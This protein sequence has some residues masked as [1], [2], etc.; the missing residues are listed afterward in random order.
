MLEIREEADSYGKKLKGVLATA[1]AIGNDPKTLGAFALN[2]GIEAVEK[3]NHGMH[4]FH[5]MGMTGGQ[6]LEAQ[7]QS[8]SVASLMGLSDTKGAIQGIVEQYGTLAGASAEVTD[9]IGHLAHEMGISGAEAGKLTAEMS[10]MAG[11][12]M[13]T[14]A[15]TLEFTKN[16]AKASGVA[17]GKLTKE[18]AANTKDMALFSKE[19]SKG[20]AKAAMELHKMNVS[21]DAAASAANS[22]LDYETSIEAQ[23]EASALLGREINLDKARELALNHDSAGAMKELVNQAGGLANF[24][25]MNVLEQQ[26]LA[27]AIGLQPAELQ[28]AMEAQ[29][30]QNKLIGEGEAAQSGYMAKLLMV[31][32][33]GVKLMQEYG[34][35]MMVMLQFLTSQVAMQGLGNALQFGKNILIAAGNGLLLVGKGIAFATSLI[36]S[37]ER[38]AAAAE[39]IKTAAKWAAEKAHI[40]FMI[41]KYA[42]LK[43]AAAFGI[44]GAAG[45]A[46]KAKEAVTNKLKEKTTAKIKEKGG[47]LAGKAGDKAL[48]KTTEKGGDLVNKTTDKAAETATKAQKV[49]KTSG[50]IGATLKD[51]ASGIKAFG[52][53]KVLMGAGVMIVAAIGLAAM[54]AG[55]PTLL[56]ISGIGTVAG[57]GLKGLAGGIKS[58]GSGKVAMG[59]GVMLA[60]A[61]SI[62]ALGAATILFA[63]GGVAGTA[64][65]IISLIAL[66]AALAILGALGM[67]GIGFV[68]VALVLAVGVAMLLLGAAVLI[69]AIGIAMVVDSFTKMFEVVS[70]E[71]IGALLLLGPALS[72][73]GA[74][75]LVMAVGLLV[76]APALLLFGVAAFLASFG[77]GALGIGFALLGVG[78]A[79]VAGGFFLMS[80]VLNKD[81]ISLL[82][83]LV[84]VTA[85]LGLGLLSLGVSAL[86]ATP[87]LLLGS[88]SVGFMAAA[89]GLLAVVLTAAIPGMLLLIQLGSMAGAFA[90]IAISMAAMAA[91]V[92]SFAAAGL[93]TLPTIMGLIAL[94]F[95]APILTALGDSINYDLEGGSSVQSKPE[96]DKMNILIE[97]V[98]GLKAIMAQGGVINMD[99]KKVGDVLRLSTSTSNLR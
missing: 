58:F 69:A 97:E 63:A 22:L 49:P 90:E 75:M 80:K 59:A 85:L 31:G 42:V 4:E 61:A 11:E 98:R 57:V 13:A 72:L 12:S 86:V 32:S 92:A 87:G 39:M 29:E 89:V 62:A 60:A 36:Y 94:S 15:E 70:M 84:P 26:K 91:G 24:Q 46:D 10:M 23:M 67:A 17:P 41:A 56:V 8:L 30:G 7:M 19:G 44:P 6:A 37:A 82:A 77:V 50:G 16:L 65:M 2:Q 21:M 33:G 28:K 68:G 5:E 52:N 93:L 64:L 88:L 14:S 25:A 27:A 54:V 95:V 73:I 40:A 38:R 74:G 45:A 78:V 99:G 20:F 96:D 79:M 51:V 3:L 83:E 18:M 1:R 35:A 53:S 9:H 47:D 55:I 43:A 81:F 66:T 71:N 76:A 34:M 48:D